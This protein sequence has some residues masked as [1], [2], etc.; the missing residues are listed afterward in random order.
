MARKNKR[1][2][3]GLIPGLEDFNKT[4]GI[5]HRKISLYGDNSPKPID[6]KALFLV[7]FVYFAEI[8]T[9]LLGIAK[10]VEILRILYGR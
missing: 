5:D 6:F 3:D 10:I 1:N 8:T 2:E 9:I 7:I 4:V